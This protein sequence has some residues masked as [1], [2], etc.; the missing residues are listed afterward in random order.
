MQYHEQR[1]YIV[2]TD[3]SMACID[4]SE[5]A[6]TAANG[7]SVPVPLDVKA[8]AATTYQP[9]TELVTVSATTAPTGTGV[10][11]ECMDV[12]GRL[13]IRVTGSG[14]VYHADWNV[15]FPREYRVAG[16]RYLV[17]DLVASERGFYRIRGEIKRLL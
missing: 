8:A 2:T 11:V 12:R 6:I 16:T 3:G 1:L 5:Q 17:D 15:Q 14:S 4:V 9:A 7:G 10:I 13:R